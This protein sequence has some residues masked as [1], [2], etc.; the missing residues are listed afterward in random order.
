VLKNLPPESPMRRRMKQIHPERPQNDTRN[1][2]KEAYL[3]PKVEEIPP[4]ISKNTKKASSKQTYIKD[5]F[6]INS[7]DSNEKELGKV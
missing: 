3:V 1:F 2:F 7:H 4:P 5:N 6:S